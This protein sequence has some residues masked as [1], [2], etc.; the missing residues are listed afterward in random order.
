LAKNSA[1]QIRTTQESRGIIGLISSTTELGNE[2]VENDDEVVDDDQEEEEEKMSEQEEFVI[3]RSM[4]EIYRISNR[5]RRN[6]KSSSPG[7]PEPNQRELEELAKA[8]AILQARSAEGKN[9]IDIIPGSPK[10]QRTKSTGAAS[11]SSSDEAPGHD[12]QGTSREDDIALMQEIGWIESKEEIDC[13]LKQGQQHTDGDDDES[14]DDGGKRGDTPKPFDYSNVGPIG[15]FTPTPPANPFF[16]GA[17]LTGGHLNQ[18]FGKTEKKKQP[19]TAR[20]GKPSRRQA[21]RPEK[22]E[23]RSQAYKKR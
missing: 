17:A 14:S 16:A 1:A 10:R 23:G 21:E 6:K 15:A 3:P 5:N 9:Y 20:G 7:P 4:R 12:S 18:Q 8:E 13:M 22:R 2:Q 11:L 19:G